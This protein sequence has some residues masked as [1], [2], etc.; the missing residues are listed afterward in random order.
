MKAGACAFVLPKYDNAKYINITLG[1]HFGMEDLVHSVINNDDIM[2]SDW[3]SHKERLTRAFTVVGAENDGKSQIM[4]RDIQD[5]YRMQV[6]FSDVYESMFNECY[7]RLEK[8][9]NHKL[10]AMKTCH[11]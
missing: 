11:K 3:V 10:Q 1:Y 5:L 7:S 6:E 4:C 2:M 9:L 8:A